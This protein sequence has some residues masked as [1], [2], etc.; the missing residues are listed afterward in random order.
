MILIFSFWL[1]IHG[2]GINPLM[3]LHFTS[4]SC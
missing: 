4:T 2:N 1:F 3:S